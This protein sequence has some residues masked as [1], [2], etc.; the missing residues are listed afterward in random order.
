MFKLQTQRLILR[1]WSLN[2]VDAFAAL[3]SDPEV[4]RYMP[5]LLSYDESKD[6]ILWNQ[7]FFKK[8]GFCFF[9]VELISSGEFIGFIGLNEP[10]F[11]AYFTPCV[12][13]GWRLHKKFW[14]QG[15]ATEGAKACLEFGIDELKLKQI[16][17]FTASINLPSRKVMERI[18]MQYDPNGDFAHPRLP[19]DHELSYHVLYKI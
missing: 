7:E 18:G 3:N 2:D 15:Y 4:M 5:K 19:K 1:E 14:H 16:Y 9:A 10:T 17:S 11:E 12:E 6:W 13:I 8:K